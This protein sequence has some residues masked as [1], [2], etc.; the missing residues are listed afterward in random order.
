L[1]S[2]Q[3]DTAQKEK[4]EEKEMNVTVLQ[5]FIMELNGETIKAA[6]KKVGSVFLDEG[7][8]KWKVVEDK[9]KKKFKL[10]TKL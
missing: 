5:S 1:D 6:N 9:G 10:V 4:K 7:L 2:D 8:N 3:E